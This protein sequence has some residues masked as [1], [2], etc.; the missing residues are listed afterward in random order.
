MDSFSPKQEKEMLL[1][2]AMEISA[3]QEKHSSSQN[4]NARERKRYCDFNCL[5]QEGGVKGSSAHPTVMGDKQRRK[6]TLK[7]LLSSILNSLIFLFN[8]FDC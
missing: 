5:E 3:I 2:I 8:F 7:I 6:T 4:S 1:L